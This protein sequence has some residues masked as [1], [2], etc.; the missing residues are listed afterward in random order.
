MRLPTAAVFLLG[1]SFCAPASAQTG[2]AAAYPGDEG[3]AA[4]PRVLLF[5][6]FEKA[7]VSE[8]SGRW[9]NVANPGNLS[10]ESQGPVGGAADQR[11]LRI[12]ARPGAETGGHLYT[13]LPPQQRLHLRYYVKYAAGGTFHHSGAWLGAYN[14]ST[15]WPQGGAGQR[16]VGNERFTVGF[17]PT[18]GA[19]RWDLYAYWM[20][21]RPDGSGTYWGNTL[22]NDPDRRVQPDRWT[23]IE[24]MIEMNDP[25]DGR[26]GT[27]AAWIDGTRVAHLGPGFPMGAW[28]GG[29]FTPGAGT[30]PF[31]G[32]QWRADPALATNFVWLQLH[33]TEDPRGSL[34]FDQVVAATEYIGPI[35]ARD[36]DLDGIPDDADNCPDFAAADG[37]DQDGNGIGDKCECGD[38]N[39]DGRVDV[40]DLVAINLAIFE[41]SRVSPLCDTNE[42]DVCDV[43]DVVGALHKIFGTPAHCSRS[44]GSEPGHQS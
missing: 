31:E 6:N 21:M 8:L 37:S 16:P 27:L 7:A 39:G 15:A 44:P 3:I 29:A 4:D 24:L 40:L 30:Q 13:R 34:W 20:G 2:L 23:C 43:R 35:A 33:T 14:P 26:T 25:V 22:L 11:S 41:P 19:L 1:L 42:D 17:E 18:G 9:E 28:S 32:F 10:L 5:E 38:Q 12:V 36:A